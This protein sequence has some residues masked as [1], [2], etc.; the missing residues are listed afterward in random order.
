[1][2]GRLTSC[3]VDDNNTLT[4]LLRMAG[5]RVHFSGQSINEQLAQHAVNDPLDQLLFDEYIDDA[6]FEQPG[7]SPKLRRVEVKLA[8]AVGARE[9][10]MAHLDSSFDVAGLSRLEQSLGLTGSIKL[11]ASVACAWMD[12]F[13]AVRGPLQPA[14]RA[15]RDAL[16]Q[17]LR[18]R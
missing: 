17:H 1:M 3:T 2:N 16:Q 5:S 8:G 6:L 13:C 4:G 11:R 9:H 15:V 12:R 10:G 18:H 7:L 14:L